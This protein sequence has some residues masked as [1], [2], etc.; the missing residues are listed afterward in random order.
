MN[1]QG[2]FAQGTA[3]LRK[4]NVQILSYQEVMNSPELTEL[5][6]SRG[7][8]FM[9]LE[10]ETLTFQPLD[11]AIFF[12]STFKAANG[13]KYN[14]LKTLAVSDKRGLVRV[15]APALCRIPSL[16]SEQEELFADNLLGKQFAEAEA[17][18]LR[19][20]L[21]CE[22]GQIVV[23]QRILMHQDRWVTNKETNERERIPDSEDLP[24]RKQ[25]VC[26]K[27]AKAA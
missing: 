10:G 20:Q 4:E 3:S 1:E 7:L 18:W 5:G 25:L 27:F 16:E 13:Q 12:V 24:N 15:P 6:Q 23:K 19:L 2:L 8:P 21:C 11:Q 26:F 17:D 14:I 9:F 22:L